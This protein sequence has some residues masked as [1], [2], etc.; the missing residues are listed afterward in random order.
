MGFFEKVKN[1][2]TEEVEDDDVKVEQVKG[3]TTKVSF[4]PAKKEEEPEEKFEE[5][6]K[7][8]KIEKDFEETKVNKPVFFDDDDFK[9]L[10]FGGK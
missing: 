1:M 5:T 3:E 2:F 9:D 7:I 10:S 6:K 8:E 4:E